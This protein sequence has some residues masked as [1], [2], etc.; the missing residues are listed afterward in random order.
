MI[1][2]NGLMSYPWG[3]VCKAYVTSLLS[4]LVYHN[5]FRL[6]TNCLFKHTNSSMD[7]YSCVVTRLISHLCVC[8]NMYQKIAS[9]FASIHVSAS[10]YTPVCLISHLCVCICRVAWGASMSRWLC[11]RPHSIM[12]CDVMHKYCII[13]WNT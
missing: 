4:T 10:Y 8:M 12:Q 9:V 1:E 2:A 6:K 3:C 11:I 7:S 13:L 5:L